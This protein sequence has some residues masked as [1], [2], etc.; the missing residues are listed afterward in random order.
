[1]FLTS[2]EVRTENSYFSLRVIREVNFYPNVLCTLFY[3]RN[4]NV[5]EL[6]VLV[7]LVLKVYFQTGNQ[8]HAWCFQDW[9][10]GLSDFGR[11]VAVLVL[12]SIAVVH[13]L[14]A[15][16]PFVL[17]ILLETCTLHLPAST[18][19]SCTQFTLNG[20]TTLIGV[21]HFIC[22]ILSGGTL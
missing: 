21:Y 20:P 12:K 4:I 13:I 8:H 22:F 19:I 18:L 15:T 11:G 1:M 3:T 9:A 7:E 14:N 5:P 16:L 10:L 17:P 2:S 6:F